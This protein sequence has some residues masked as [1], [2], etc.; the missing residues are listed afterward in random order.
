M[1]T[2]LSL[3]MPPN[4]VF[5]PVTSA[6]QNNITFTEY[7][8]GILK[9]LNETIAV[10][11]ENSEYIKEFDSKYQELLTEF[12]ELKS[13][14]EGLKEDILNEVTQKLSDFYASVENEIALAVNYMRAYTD[15]KYAILDNKIDQVTLGNIKLIDPTT[16]LMTP[17]Q[18]VIN[19][20]SGVGA[21]NLTATE[22]DALEL[23]ATSYDGYDI[24]AFDYDYHAKTI[25][26]A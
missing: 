14:F 18:D 3:Q 9:K 5:Q 12:A 17:L 20:I 25:L 22:Y 15:S 26:M 2:K 19:N 11:N 6:F 4:S 13:E 23:S 10:T 16:G 7:L 24:S 8:L 1:I 21:D